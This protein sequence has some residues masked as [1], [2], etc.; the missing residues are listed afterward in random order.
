MCSVQYTIEKTFLEHFKI[1][2]LK[3]GHGHIGHIRMSQFETIKIS[4]GQKQKFR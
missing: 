3:N 1:T 4:S 2:K